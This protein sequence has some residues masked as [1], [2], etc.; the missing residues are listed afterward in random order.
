MTGTKHDSGKL[1]WHLFPWSAAR[2]VVAVLA[3][4]ASVYGEYNW[5]HGMAYSRLYSAAIRHLTAWWEREDDDPET[6]LSHLAH[7]V[8]CI[9]FLLTYRIT[10]RGSDDRAEV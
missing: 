3:F 5:T 2:Q 8:A 7:A 9:L 6:G 4:G 1:P 10:G